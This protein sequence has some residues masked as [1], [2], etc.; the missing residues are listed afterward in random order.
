MIPLD[1]GLLQAILAEP[2]N[3]ALRL[4]CA[5][6]W[7]EQGEAARAEFVRVQVELTMRE[8]YAG[9]D[10]SRWSDE[11]KRRMEKLRR[12]EQELLEKHGSIWIAEML[13]GA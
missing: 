10:R 11:L 13:Q 9:T 3:D 5:D 8:G 2:D 4:V 12:R 1:P 6:W 7:D